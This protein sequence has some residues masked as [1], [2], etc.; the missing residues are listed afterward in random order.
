[1]EGIEPLVSV[2]ISKNQT[3]T[4]SDFRKRLLELELD[5]LFFEEL[6][7]K[8]DSLA[9]FVC[10]IGTGNRTETNNFKKEKEKERRLT[11]S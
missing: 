7:P 11:C 1:L 8:K 5:F 10:G 6:D 3:G 4:R 9:P 2:L